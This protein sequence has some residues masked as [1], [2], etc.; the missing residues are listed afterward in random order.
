MTASELRVARPQ[1]VGQM[2][3][4]SDQAFGLRQSRRLAAADLRLFPFRVAPFA[5]NQEQYDQKITK[6][7]QNGTDQRLDKRSTDRPSGNIGRYC[8]DHQHGKHSGQEPW[9]RHSGPPHRP[10]LAMSPKPRQQYPPHYVRN[11]APGCISTAGTPGV[12]S[13][14][15]AYQPRLEDILSGVS[16]QGES[17]VAWPRRGCLHRLQALVRTRGYSSP[18]RPCMEHFCD[19]HDQISRPGERQ[20]DS[21]LEANWSMLNHLYVR[22]LH[23]NNLL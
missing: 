15:R 7:Q 9:Q 13:F 2:A 22:K 20:F 1:K 6:L 10:K 5:S 19:R 8:E 3:D 16:R 21:T 11:F 17:R 23:N 12:R 18:L 14:S 4:S